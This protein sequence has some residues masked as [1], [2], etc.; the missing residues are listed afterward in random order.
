MVFDKLISNFVAKLNV[1]SLVLS[2]GMFLIAIEAKR[3]ISSFAT[4]LIT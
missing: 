4:T 1:L 3:T 2:E